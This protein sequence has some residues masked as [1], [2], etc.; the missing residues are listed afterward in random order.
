MPSY[1]PNAAPSGAQAVLSPPLLSPTTLKNKRDAVETPEQAYAICKGTEWSNRIIITRAAQAQRK[2]DGEPPY[3]SFKLRNKGQFWKSNISTG[4]LAS[5]IERVFPRFY[6]RLRNARYL[7]AAELPSTVNGE[8][9]P[10]AEQK[11][12]IFREVFTKT[13]RKWEGCSAFMQMLSMETCGYGYCFPTFLDNSDWRPQLLRLDEG[14]V[15]EGT[16]AMTQKF[17]YFVTRQNFTV[18][19][20]IDMIR[21]PDAAE[22]MGWDLDNVTSALNI[23]QPVPRQVAGLPIDARRYEDTIRELIPVEGFQEGANM[24]KVYRLIYKEYDG[25]VSERILQ[26][27][28]GA[29]LFYKQNKYAS[30]ADVV[31]P[32]VFQIG[33]GT[34]YGSEGIAIKLYALAMNVEKS[35]NSAQ[36]AFRNRNR[37]TMATASAADLE[38][39]KLQVYDD[40]VVMAGG[41]FQ[42]NSGALPAVVEDFIKQ[43]TFWTQLAEQRAG[44][45]MPMIME[46][47]G[48]DTTATEAQIN[49]GRQK[50]VQDTTLDNMFLQAQVLMGMVARKMFDPLT[51]D[52][53]A[54]AAQSECQSRGLSLGEMLFLAKQAAT[55]NI[56]ILEQRQALEAQFLQTRIGNPLW[57]QYLIEQEIGTRAIG[58]DLTKLLM[59]PQGD[60]SSVIKGTRS[61]ELENTTM[62]QGRPVPVAPD[63]PHLIHMATIEG[64]QDPATG[65]YNNS[66]TQNLATHNI[67]GASMILAHY[68]NHRDTAVATKTNGE[69][70]QQNHQEAFIATMQ[71]LVESATQRQQQMAQQQLIQ[72]TIAQPMPPPGQPV[73][74]LPPAPGAI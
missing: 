68:I 28:T 33:N 20:I 32:F 69:G 66:I 25:S 18:Q 45:L 36:D 19:E 74:Q 70:N 11:T 47:D 14:F 7:T 54:M 43:D 48:G 51:E 10:A 15:P 17:P 53:D 72:Q 29:E 40:Y 4:F 30:M 60:Q 41:T 59:V 5:I 46:Q 3:N 57:D 1:P 62:G 64:Q 67:P 52:E 21:D 38:K 56:G 16:K 65:A 37:Y 8:P 35:R 31:L 2:I 34:V 39:M 55:G 12:Q 26:R 9:V 24:V 27:D 49:A 44:A 58:S 50:E 42:N 13:F 71:K 6:M 22:E 63:D 23:A 73:G 61:Q